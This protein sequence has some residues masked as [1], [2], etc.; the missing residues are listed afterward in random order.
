MLPNSYNSSQTTPAPASVSGRSAEVA[1][2]WEQE[3]GPDSV[4]QDTWLVS[5]ADILML[6]LTLFVILLAF[7][8]GAESVQLGNTDVT[9][10]Q[11]AVPAAAMVEVPA[12]TLEPSA[13]DALVSVEAET[14]AA[15]VQEQASLP[16]GSGMTS[17]LIPQA[18][19]VAVQATAVTVEESNIPAAA[20][21][22]QTVENAVVEPQPMTASQLPDAPVA[23]ALPSLRIAAPTPLVSMAGM[24]GMFGM[25]EQFDLWP[26]PPQA[27]RS[28]VER[29]AEKLLAELQDSRLQGRVEVTVLP[30]SV[31]L[32]ISDSILFAPA[33]AELTQDGMRLLDELAATLTAHPYDLSVEGH[34]D[35]VPIKTAR[36]P[37]N[38]E[39]S[40][41]RAT[42]V[43]RRLIERGIAGERVRAIG[44]ADTRPR[45]DNATGEGK[46]RNRR[47]S[48]VLMEQR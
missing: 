7:K 39:L 28:T 11:A 25:P 45:A 37:S 26:Q 18:Q 35:N 15:D 2:P 27:T 36:Y 20:E 29:N 46:A 42:E 10:Q 16:P 21:S 8:D 48:L 40:A 9:V 32:E 33:S 13:S 5:F 41:A 12:S 34:T 19:P 47:V 17:T 6:L 24:P 43:T 23:T 3:L 22:A 14:P 44:Y 30:D 38:W 31:S 1:W 4:D